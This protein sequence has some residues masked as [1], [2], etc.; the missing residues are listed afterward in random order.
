MG[1]E[2]QNEQPADFSDRL[3]N[4]D[5]APRP[6]YLDASP[7]YTHRESR[8]INWT[9]KYSRG[10]LKNKHQ[11]TYFLVGISALF[12]AASAMVLW[13]S[14]REPLKIPAK[15]RGNIPNTPKYN[16]L[17]PKGFTLIELL[18]II[19]MIS[20]LASI[21]LAFLQSARMKARDT[22]RIVA[23]EQIEKAVNLYVITN[24]NYP[25]ANTTNKY[26]WSL[27]GG[28]VYYAGS[29]SND[30]RASSGGEIRFWADLEQ[31]LAQYIPKLP[32]D[33][34][35]S[36]TPDYQDYAYDYAAYFDADGKPA[37]VYLDVATCSVSKNGPGIPYYGYIISKLEIATPNFTE[38]V[39]NCWP[40]GEK[41]QII[42][43]ELN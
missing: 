10:L 8:L 39:Q 20:L 31:E 38:I 29:L 19:S 40:G 5:L 7:F 24:N 32:V 43:L 16:G 26:A 1:I 23:L 33:P 13:L 9:I 21:V 6:K 12:F 30:N 2:P 25:L 41:Y 36:V 28:T 35:N 17:R 34:I 22:K 14:F 27:S 18:V 4:V 15:F 42:F 11:A 3:K 37:V